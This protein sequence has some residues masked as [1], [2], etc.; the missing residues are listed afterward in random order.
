MLVNKGLAE[1]KNLIESDTVYKIE[2]NSLEPVNLITD[3]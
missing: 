3:Y 2:T 1:F